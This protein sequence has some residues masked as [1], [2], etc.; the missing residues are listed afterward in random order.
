MPKVN[1]S[2]DID[3]YN[4]WVK[5]KMQTIEAMTT[6]EEI[7]ARIVEIAKI[8]FFAKSEWKLLHDRNDVLTGRRSIPTWLKNERARLITE[9]NI[10]IDYEKE[11][12]E[13][14]KS[15]GPKAPKEDSVKKLLGIDSSELKKQIQQMKEKKLSQAEEPKLSPIEQLMNIPAKEKVSA[16]EIANRAAA[17]KERMRLAK[18]GK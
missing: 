5:D 1:Y 16:D 6:I 7:E 3:I 14:K 13:K 9:P 4:A 17:M 12:R 8:E 11:P 18:E 2:V 10:V 15:S